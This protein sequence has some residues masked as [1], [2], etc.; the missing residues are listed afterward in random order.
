MFRKLGE[1]KKLKQLIRETAKFEQ[2]LQDML[3]WQEQIKKEPQDDKT[4]VPG[5]NTSSGEFKREGSKC[6]QEDGGCGSNSGNVPCSGC[7]KN[8]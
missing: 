1:S 5:S 4:I 6:I 3:K 2:E 8:R 7:I